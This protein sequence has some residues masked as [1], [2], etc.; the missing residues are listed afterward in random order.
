[1]T[2]ERR[3]TFLTNHG[4][5]LLAVA[6]APDLRVAEIAAQVGITPRAALAILRDLEDTGYVRR[7]RVGRRTHYTVQPHQP[8]RH[9]AAAAHEVD[10]LLAILGSPSPPG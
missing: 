2:G 10:E 5:V 4:H 8:F 6:G 9:P 3:W 1:M 7:T